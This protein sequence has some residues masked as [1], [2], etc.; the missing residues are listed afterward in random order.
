MGI[1][2]PFEREQMMQDKDLAEIFWWQGLQVHS[3]NLMSLWR[4]TPHLSQISL[5]ILFGG[6]LALNIKVLLRIIFE[7]L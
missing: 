5:C 2:T 3:F 4:P 7:G 6:N 1:K